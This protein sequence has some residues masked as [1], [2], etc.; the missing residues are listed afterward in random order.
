MD[1]VKSVGLEF[2][3][4]VSLHA[5]PFQC[6]E[7]LWFEDMKGWEEWTFQTS[8][9]VYAVPARLE[10]L[11]IDIW[12]VAM[13]WLDGLG[14]GNLS[15]SNIGCNQLVSLGEEEEQGL[16]YNLQQLIIEDCPK[17]VSFPEKGF[18]LMLRARVST[19]GNNASPFQQHSQL[20]FKSWISHNVISRIL[21]TG[22]FPST[23]K[24]ITIDNCAQLQPIS[25]EM[26]H[27]NNNELEKL[28][29]SRHPNL[30]TIPDCLYN[31][32]DLRIEKCENLDLQPHL[33]RN[34]TSLASL[35]ITNCENI[36][37]PLSEWGLA[38]LTSLRTLTI[39]GIFPEAT[40]FSNH[41]HHLFLLP[42]TLVELCISRF[43]NLESLPSCLSKRSPLLES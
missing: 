39:G 22:K 11:E 2:E 42:T 40:S 29:I 8:A 7:S 13:L 1:G 12:S 34:L 33:L 15:L 19:R 9:G 5:T 35:Q 28:S 17:L 20:C 16:P 23:L 21:P 4:Q 14:L 43:Q 3:G 38:R 41:H 32:K 6:L 24:S 31:L 26:F 18:P 27:C 10:L 30:K 37:V 36:K 25:E